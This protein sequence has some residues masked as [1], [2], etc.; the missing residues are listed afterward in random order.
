MSIESSE[1]LENINAYGNKQDSTSPFGLSDSRIDAFLLSIQ[2][3]KIA[4]FSAS[5]KIQTQSMSIAE[6]QYAKGNI[7]IKEIMK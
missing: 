6:G 1:M 5:G 3:D 2:G 4:R 7:T